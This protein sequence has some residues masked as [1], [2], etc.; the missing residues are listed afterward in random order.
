M[1]AGERA[2][3]WTTLR[4][5]ASLVRLSHTVFGLPFALA[6]AGIA[7]RA[8][9]MAGAEGMTWPKLGWVVLAFT[10]A[11]TAAMGF[12]RIVDRHID[13]QNPRTAS[14][15]LPS[16]AI[17]VGAAWTLTLLS[18]LGFVGA[19]WA[20]GPLPLLL[21]PI[22]LLVIFGYSLFKRFSW[23]AHLVLGVA[24]SLAPGGAWVAITGTLEG[25]PTPTLLMV[26][27][28]TWVAGFDI[29][30][31]LQD[32]DFD[33]EQGLH[34]IPV[35]LGVT[36]ALV[37]S[38]LLHL[39]TVAALVGMHLWAGLGALHA[40]GIGLIALILAYEH[41]IVRPGDLSRIDRAFFDL[42]GYVSIGYLACTLADL[43]LL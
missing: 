23:S 3:P 19:A 7:D 2:G 13:A 14:R 33:R 37:A 34:S 20:L 28:A 8:A 36:G 1:D 9:T 18:A 42:N 41:W 38:G 16:G 21:S 22:C 43:Y 12:N 25:W 29:F 26:A 10:A 40:V 39:G 11:R 32:A 30:Y 5:F 27:V 15:E 31:S 6:A 17:S 4:R 24:L 35:R